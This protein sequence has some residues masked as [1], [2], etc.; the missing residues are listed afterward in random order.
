[1]SQAEG[2]GENM[3]IQRAKNTVL[4][5]DPKNRK[6]EPKRR[7]LIIVRQDH[8]SWADRQVLGL[9]HSNVWCP[10]GWFNMYMAGCKYVWGTGGIELTQ[11]F[12]IRN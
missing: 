2:E 4:M 9:S 11:N 8:E 12:T 10:A 5:S 6:R 3:H 7:C 1:M